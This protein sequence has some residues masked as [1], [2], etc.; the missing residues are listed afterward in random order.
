MFRQTDELTAPFTL[1]PDIQ[2]IP[3]KGPEPDTAATDGEK[4]ENL[5]RTAEQAGLPERSA[6]SN[7]RS[8]TEAELEAEQVNKRGKVAEEKNGDD[9]IVID[10]D[11]SIVVD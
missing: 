9:T 11:G 7:K 6:Q 4:S 5:K 10:D 3:R 2:T 8:A 1:I